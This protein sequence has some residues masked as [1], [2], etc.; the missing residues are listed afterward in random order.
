MIQHKLRH[1]FF[2][3][4]IQKRNNILVLTVKHGKIYSLLGKP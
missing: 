4:F 3:K 1:V 2:I